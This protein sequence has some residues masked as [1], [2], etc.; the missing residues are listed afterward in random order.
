MENNFLLTE[1][2]I[3]DYVDGV[4]TAED[5][6]QVDAYLRQHPEWEAK[7]QAIRA[8]KC[9]LFAHH[10]EKPDRG[11]SDRVL[12]AWA[13]E[14]VEAHALAAA[15]AKRD[16]VIRVIAI[17]FSVFVITPVVVL[18]VMALQSAPVELPTIKMPEIETE[19]WTSLLGSSVLQ[20]GLLS[21]LAIAFL[22]LADQFLHKR[23]IVRG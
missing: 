2:M 16:W 9:S 12:A 15:P 1:E 14:Q 11:F 3:W 10:M 21:L 13:S 19:R 7:M 8:E 23:F 6:N 5:K 22:K 20:L 17:A 18:M 4:L